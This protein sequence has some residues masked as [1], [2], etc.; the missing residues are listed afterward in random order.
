[1]ILVINDDQ[2]LCDSI[3]DMF[4]L[5]GMPCYGA[6]IE[7]AIKEPRNL[8]SLLLLPEPFYTDDV[9][10]M[11][12]NIGGVFQDLPICKVGIPNSFDAGLFDRVIY[13]GGDLGGVLSGIVNMVK[14]TFN[15]ENYNIGY[16]KAPTDEKNI[17]LGKNKIGLTKTEGLLLRCI[18]RS[19]TGGCTKEDLLKYC[20]RRGS[21]TEVSAIRTHICAINKKVMEICNQKLIFSE[22]RRYYIGENITENRAG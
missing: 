1:M 22:N 10:K 20:F 13:P 5:Q 12:E 6:K 19:G 9:R 8:Y 3:T 15:I 11:V 18:M 7:D 14:N 17:Y 16:L 4:R 2:E 21:Y